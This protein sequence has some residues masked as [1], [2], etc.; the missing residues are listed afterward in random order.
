MS[1]LIPLRKPLLER[2]QRYVKVHTT[3]D[4]A[5]TTVPTTPQQWDLLR[6]LRDEVTA[7]GMTEVSLDDKGYLF[8]TLPATT[9]KKVPVL[10]F[11]AHVDT[12]PECSGENV[13]PQVIENYGGGDI[14]LKGSGAVLSPKEFPALDG[15]HGHTLVTTDGTTLLGADDKSGIAIILSAVEYLLAHPE[16]PHGKIRVAFTPDEEIGRGPKHFDVKA[17]G[18]DVAYTV[19]GGPLGELQYEYSVRLPYCPGTSEMS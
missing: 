6:L 1:A 5:S 18:A 14:P 13:K 4:A 7:L 8:A 19:D 12:S 2:L 3:S 16:I 10:G 17:F 9:D 15:L 11:M